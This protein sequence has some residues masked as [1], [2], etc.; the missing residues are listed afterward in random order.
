V[1]MRGGE[2]WVGRLT[3]DLSVALAFYTRLPL[4]Y[5][6]A[7]TG[8]DLARASWAA[9]IAGAVVGAVGALAYGLA[10]AAGLG[11]LPASGLALAAT[12]AFT[13]ALHEDGLADSADAFGATASPE[14]RLVIMRDSRI[15]TFGACALILSI[16]LRWAA[17]AS[18][19]SP[20]RAAAVLIAAHAGARAVP[21]L[22]MLLIP[23]ARPDGLSAAAGLPPAD[24]VAAAA[25]LGLTALILALGLAN[26]LIAAALLALCLFAMR[27]LALN[28]IGG[29][30]GDVLGALEQVCEVVVLLVAARG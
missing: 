15:G 16:A 3:R 17:L 29:Q 8:E 26:A 24:S 1:N 7:F 19:T 4:P 22:L 20:T 18:V 28:K 14:E 25:V 9:P 30:S 27:R 5:D 23:P 21:P 12:L 2:D 6:R 10:H 13:G 11:A